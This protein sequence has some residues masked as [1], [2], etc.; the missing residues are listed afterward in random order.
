MSTRPARPHARTA[1]SLTGPNGP[2]AVL[3]RRLA[4]AT[5][6]FSQ[7]MAAR[8]APGSPI[9]RAASTPPVLRFLAHFSLLTAFS[10]PGLR[11]ECM[12]RLLQRL[13]CWYTKPQPLRH[14]ERRSLSSAH[15]FPGLHWHLNMQC[16]HHLILNYSSFVQAETAW[17][18]TG[19]HG[20]IAPL[21]PPAALAPRPGRAGSPSLR[22]ARASLAPLLSPRRKH[23][24]EPVA[25]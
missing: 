23:A 6:R 14:S 11:L 20:P 21:P 12:D 22:T 9:A 1:L 2:A 4:T 17:S 10:L 3:D 7:R 18:L 15:R 16:A 24:Q 25:V 8:S 5:S 13:R 19:P